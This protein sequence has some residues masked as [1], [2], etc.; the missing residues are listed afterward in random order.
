[1]ISVTEYLDLTAKRFPNKTAIVDAD[2]SVSFGELKHRAYLIAAIIADKGLSKKP[3]IV[4]T[5]KKAKC[6]IAFMGISYSGCFYCPIDV[7][8]PIV[9]INKIVSTLSPN[10][11]ITDLK[12]YDRAI[13]CFPD[14]EI[15]VYDEIIRDSNYGEKVIETVNRV[16]SQIID[17]DVLYVLFT[18]GSTGDPKGVTISHR[19]VVDYTE[20]VTGFFG[21]NE[22]DVFA[23]QAP[24]YFDNS[25]LDIYQMLKTGAT[26]HIVPTELYAFP[27]DLLCYL[28]D[29]EVSVIFWVPSALCHVANMRV[30]HKHHVD[31]LRAV[32]FCGEVM[33]NKQLNQWRSEYKDT[34]FANL[35]GP[36]EITDAC[37]VFVVNREF[38]DDEP[39]PI[40]F[41]CANTDILVLNQE[42]TRVVG[43]EKGELCVRG[44]CLSYGYYNNPEKTTLAFVQNPTNPYYREIIYR[45]GDIV[46][47]N[48]RGEL[49]YDSR[50][51]FQIKH[52]GH[53]IEL[54]EIENATMS[55]EGINN[56]CCV[57][58]EKKNRIVLFYV[59]EVADDT[60]LELLKVRIPNYMLPGKRVRIERM[61][62][63]ANGKIDRVEMKARV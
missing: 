7:D 11:I 53:R 12:N 6:I 22:R 37:T 1:M 63:N 48:N 58:D 33:P 44:T 10:L 46:H 32:L 38:S 39:L 17:T 49:M 21:F 18:S 26:M 45:T 19:A 50:K 43:D 41:P 42:N 29:N 15:L 27:A 55:I 36:T 28:N 54:G 14:I 25:I 40:G 57:Y 2:E 62:L 35:Y 56:C 3:V 4:F 23:N 61:P 20:W 13:E 5:E 59:G 8:M 31:S 60:I 52:M 30:L 24:F 9:R 47:Y 34:L 51:D 16:K